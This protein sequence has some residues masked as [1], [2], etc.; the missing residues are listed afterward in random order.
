[1][2]GSTTLGEFLR[3]RRARLRPQQAGLPGPSARR[4]TPGLRREEVAALAGLSIDYYIRLEQGRERN[5]GP[6]VVDGIA[7][8]L[9]LDPDE[10]AHLRTLVEHA[11]GRA[12]PARSERTLPGSI[13][14]LLD[15]LRPCPAL[16]LARNSDVVAA[17]REGLALFAGMDRWPA[18]QRNTVRWMFARTDADTDARTVLVDWSGNA[19]ATAAGLRS[20]LA[21]DPAASDVREL[22]QELTAVSPEF[23]ALWQRYDV[24]PRRGT[25]KS[26]EHP[27]A[28]RLELVHDTLALEDPQLRLSLYQPAGPADEQALHRLGRGATSAGA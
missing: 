3:A 24:R 4:R 14:G 8:A 26:F 9:Q 16:V 21:T 13:R 15:R 22:V 5:P 27:V 19:A 28:G 11:A 25:R 23:A 6:A 10:T 12:V 2:T 7:G 20:R 1:M 17:N 18:P